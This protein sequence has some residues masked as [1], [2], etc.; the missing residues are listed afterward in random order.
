MMLTRLFLNPRSRDVHRDIG[1]SQRMHRRVM[2][3]FR[4]DVGSTAR[5]SL[6]VLHRLDRPEQRD[7]L[8]L[9]VQSDEKPDPGLLPRGFLDERAGDDAI[10]TTDLA[11]VAEALVPGASFRFRLR[12]NAT[13]RIDTKS[14]PD[15]K[16][17]NGRRV[18]VTGDDGR[19]AWLESRLKANGM[20]LVGQCQQRP[21]GRLRGAVGGALRTHEGCVFD[22]VLQVDDAAL[23][24]NAFRTGIGPAKAF[25]FGLLSLARG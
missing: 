6:G 23:A 3:L 20:R 8:I 2:S 1:D 17:R 19:L 5:A 12:A 14:G 7:A 24:R 21:E 16:R 25:G 13:R 11:A 18:P 10:A 15:G 4:D 22:G 9:L